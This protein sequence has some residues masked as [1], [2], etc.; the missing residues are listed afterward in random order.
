MLIFAAATQGYFFAKSRIWET[1]ALLLVAFTLFRPG[2]WLDIVEPPYQ[3][4]SGSEV[5]RLAGE[6]P[7]NDV[8]RMRVSG[9][10]FDN[11]GETHAFTIEAPMGP[12]G[13]GIT[14]LEQAGLNITLEGDVARVE[15]P[16]PG[17]T[18]FDAFQDFDF[19]GETPVQIE[20]VK[21]PRERIFKEI[22]YIPALLLLI[23]VVFM[24]RRRQTQPAF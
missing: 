12:S 20:N 19:Y 7:A 24:Q 11:I 4:F 23:L 14:R 5:V 1:V 13:D 15:E 3:T 2:F 8:L 17:T 22:F 9:P 18:Y 10:D 16:L 21:I 6:T